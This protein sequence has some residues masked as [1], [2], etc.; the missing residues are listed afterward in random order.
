M[1][2]VAA[3]LHLFNEKGYTATRLD[4]VALHAGI[5]KGTIY[6]YFDSKEALFNAVAREYLV[7]TLRGWKEQQLENYAGNSSNLLEELVLDFFQTIGS[8]QVGGLLI[9]V[10]SEADNFPEIVHAYHDCVIAPGIDLLRKVVMRGM[11]HREFRLVNPEVVSHIIMAPLL[12]RVIWE[13]SFS[14][15]A[16]SVP[17]EHYLAEYFDLI[18]EGFRPTRYCTITRSSK[19]ACPSSSRK[20]RV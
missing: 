12:M 13:H 8:D 6:L 1:E 17:T 15:R 5:S 3:A 18:L 2:I 10:L 16:P 11:A 7:M 19:G 9:L 14:Y 4:D 20:V